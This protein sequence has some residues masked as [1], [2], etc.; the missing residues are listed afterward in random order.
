MPTRS[1]RPNTPV[2]GM[3]KG[4]DMTASA[5]STS[6]P[7][8]NASSAATAIQWLPRRFAMKPG[9]SRHSSTTLPSWRSQAATTRAC[10]AASVA[11]PATTSS[12]SMVRGGLKKWVIVKSRA[13]A[14]EWP[15]TSSRTGMPDVLDD[16]SVPGRRSAS[17]RAYSACLTAG[18]SKTASMT[19][20]A[21]GAHGEVVV[22]VAGRDAIRE[23][24]H[25]EPARWRAAVA[26]PAL[27]SAE[28]SSPSAT[29]SSR[30]TSMPQLARWA[31]MPAPIVPAPTTTARR[32]GS[33]P[34]SEGNAGLTIGD[35]HLNLPG[36]GHGP[37]T[38]QPHRCAGSAL[39]PILPRLS[40]AADDA[41]D[42]RP[43]D[44]LRGR[45]A[46][47]ATPP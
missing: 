34:A 43:R 4:R 26:M 37:R 36:T 20:S 18:S 9:V 13:N 27:A 24:R 33:K 15:D 17:S 8:R 35:G 3:P 23:V 7:A 11:S 38:H 10:T 14:S 22:D 2:R 31:A 44:A 30:V 42:V 19:Q 47:P 45:S 1:N 39:T 12:S 6:S 46:R 28:R 29:R 41:G 32:T 21:P 25:H 40:S 5:V 16:T